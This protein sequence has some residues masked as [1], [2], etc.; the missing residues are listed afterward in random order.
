MAKRETGSSPLAGL[1][2]G[3]SEPGNADSAMIAT[4]RAPGWKQKIS[5]RLQT[6]TARWHGATQRYAKTLRELLSW[7]TSL[8]MH[9]LVILVL[10]IWTMHLPSQTPLLLSLNSSD[11]ETVLNDEPLDFEVATP[12]LLDS[13]DAIEALPSELLVDVPVEAVAPMPTPASAPVLFGEEITLLDAMSGS[14]STDGGTLEGRRGGMRGELL[15]RGGGSAASERSVALALDWLARHQHPEGYWS[16]DHQLGECQGQCD[17]PGSL[18]TSLMGATGLAL[19][20]YLGAGNTH[21]DGAHRAVVKRGVAALVKMMQVT[22]NGGSFYDGGQMYSHGIAT[23]A[24]CEAYAMTRDRSLRRPAQMAVNFTC[25]AQDPRGGGW[26]Y[27]PHQPGDTSVLGWQLGALKS[28]DLARLEVPRLVVDRAGYF[29]DSAQVGDG[30]QYVYEPTEKERRTTNATSAIGLLCRMYLGAQRDNPILKKG[31]ERIVATGPAD[32]DVYYNF[33][34]TQLVFQFSNGEGELWKK[35][36]ASMRDKLIAAQDKRGHAEG[37]W[38]PKDGDHGKDKG[39][40]LY[41]TALN[42]MTLEV[43]YRL[44]PIYQEKAVKEEFKADD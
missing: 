14:G 7:L 30:Q 8:A 20:P 27:E 33:Y 21:R 23:M 26:R 9:L 6:L 2:E 43:Y 11:D 40:R 25:Y 18:Q 19:L 15:H 37:S 29:L 10:A 32:N 16:F 34:A 44:M 36:N 12:E 1:V 24:L 17:Q 41:A 4:D 13:A 28:A 42:C 31:V 3:A 22:P 39:G 35:W 5:D 38:V